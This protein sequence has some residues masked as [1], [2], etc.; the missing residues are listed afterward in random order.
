MKVQEALEHN[1]KKGEKLWAVY[2]KHNREITTRSGMFMTEEP[3]GIIEVTVENV[4]R[5]KRE[6]VYA[7]ESLT[8]DLIANWGLDLDDVCYKDTVLYAF[9]NYENGEKIYCKSNFCI[10]KFFEKK[11]AEKRFK[12]AV[13][14]WNK[15][16]ERFQA[17]QKQKIEKVKGEY[18][19]LL[20]E[21]I[22]DINQHIIKSK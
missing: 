16:V 6:G 9:V 22:I 21:G 1:W 7:Y 19:N 17:K 11:D 13:K 4:E 3:V 15:Q 10:D 5:K 12:T 8:L 20:S 2:H 14:N 18:E